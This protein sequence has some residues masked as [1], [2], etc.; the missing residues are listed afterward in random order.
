MVTL[1]RVPD[2]R[3]L[4]FLSSRRLVETITQLQ[5]TGGRHGD[6]LVRVVLT[7]GGAGIGLLEELARLDAAAGAQSETFPTLRV[8]WSRVHIFFG[9]ERNVPVSHPD[10][11]EGQARAALLDHIS[12]PAENI[13][14]YGLG[15]KDLDEAAAEYEEKLRRLVPRGFDLHLLGMGGEGH[16]NS[17][18]PHTPEVREQE[19]LVMAV[20]NSPKPPAE[21]V[22]LTMP[23]INSSGRVW[24][25]VAGAEK[26]TAAAAVMRRAEA[27][28][29]PAAGVRGTEETVLFLADDAATELP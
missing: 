5:A 13:H 14:G 20:K 29:W 2:L 6:G 21:R 18:F 9:D 24:L 17:I 28:D 27:V 3:E 19:K 4:I 26:A 10:S 23:A 1:S 7:G 22:T 15:E 8:D 11:N 12:I 16:I 25:L